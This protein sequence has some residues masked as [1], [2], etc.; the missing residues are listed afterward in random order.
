[1]RAST[2]L[3]AVLILATSASV[4]FLGCGSGD[5][6]DDGGAGGKADA[7]ADGTT[8]GHVDSGG[9]AGDS[10][11]P[12][13]SLDG[14]A[15][16][17]DGDSSAMVVCPASAPADFSD[18]AVAAACTRF[19]YL[20]GGDNTLV[21]ASVDEGATWQSQHFHNIDG[22]DYVNNFAVYRG[23]TTATALPGV[24][25]STDPAGGYNDGGPEAGD[26]G[27]TFGQVSMI[28]SGGFDTY[29][30]ELAVNASGVFFTDNQGTYLTRDDVTWT[31]LDAGI[32]QHWYGTAA[33]AST[34]VILQDNAKFR[35]YDG[36]ALTDGV[37][38]IAPG[39]GND[40]AYGGGL[41]VAVGAANFT[42][43][44]DAKTWT[45]A[46]TIVGDGGAGFTNPNTIL[47]DGTRFLAYAGTTVAMSADTRSWTFMKLT[48][49][50]D[51]A[52]TSE[53]HFVAVG[54]L[55]SVEGILLSTD[56]LTWTMAHP[57]AAS[58]TAFINGW[59]VGLGR[60]LK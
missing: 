60:V 10:G 58:E 38:P 29:G 16:A 18:A 54:N 34:Y 57:F 33:S 35:S 12:Q 59:R 23:V 3:S 49:R 45:A 43:S 26:A 56:G 41:F 47:W 32:G 51:T 44:T 5:D 8:T 48:A 15:D 40:V 24:F 9:A 17:A 6:D 46:G 55:A 1:M 7:T 28:V 30:G 31:Q 53:G 52:A 50:I 42:T 2:K 14:A 22:D 37:L 39:G 21:I 11:P 25:Q 36:T 27:I 13:G 19:V 20:A 4:P